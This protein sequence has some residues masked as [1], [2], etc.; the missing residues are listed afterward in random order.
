MEAVADEVI[1]LINKYGANYVDFI[2]SSF[3][4]GGNKN[5]RLS[6]LCKILID[7]KIN[8]LF[9]INMRAESITKESIIYVKKMVELGLRRVYAGI[10]STDDNDLKL[11]NNKSSSKLSY[12]SVF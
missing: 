12:E 8:I 11:Y 1:T 9:G 6:D 4:D 5:E 2:D 7:R 3:E 10:E